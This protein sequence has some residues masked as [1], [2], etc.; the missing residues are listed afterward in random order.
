[1]FI[2][3]N[4]SPERKLANGSSAR[5]HSLTLQAGLEVTDDFRTRCAAAAPGTF[6]DLLEAPFAVNVQLLDV[7]AQSWPA[8]ETLVPGSVVV[9]LPPQHRSESITLRRR[10][11][12]A[13]ALKVSCKPLMYELGFA[14]TY[15]KVQG[16]TLSK[17]IL[18]LSLHPALALELPSLYVGLSRV[19]HLA[20]LRILPW[21]S[22]TTS[23][24]HLL[25]FQHD[26]KLVRWWEKYCNGGAPATAPPPLPTAS[27]TKR[28]AAATTS[29]RAHAATATSASAA[30]AAAS[31]SSVQP[32]KRAKK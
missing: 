8:S 3:E 6:V 13:A 25:K 20:D 10:R 4:L 11:A 17:I 1:V 22:V 19:R 26:D 16:Q 7:S 12:G 30:A 5:L 32:P 27:K 24:A 21:R 28:K 23:R 18:D 31:S 9:P 29:K 15:H 2:T 14:V